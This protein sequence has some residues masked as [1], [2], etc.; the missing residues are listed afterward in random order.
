MLLEF[1]A[2]VF[3]AFIMD[4]DVFFSKYAKDNN[5]R[6]LITHSI[7]PSIVLIIVGL[8]FVSPVILICGG[9]Y[10]IHILIDTF[11]WGTNFLG[12]HKKPFGLKFLITKEELDNLDDILSKYK[13]KKSFFDFRYYKNRGILI[14]EGILFG[15]MIIGIILFALEFVLFIILY[16]LFLAFH[17]SGHLHL[18]NIEATNQS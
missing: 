13:I 14:V 7:L 8:I 4:F 10:F 6:M 18:K 9:A 15:I 11:D 3:S 12:I 1:T 16:G 5:H 17:L 2:I